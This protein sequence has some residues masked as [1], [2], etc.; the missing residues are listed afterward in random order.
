MI[1]S[2]KYKFIFIKT[3]KTAGTSIEVFLSKYCGEQ[4]ILTPIDPPIE[5][6]IA[7][8]YSG[9]FNPLPEIVE[10]RFC[11]VRRTIGD[12]VRR[13]KFYNHIA[14]RIVKARVPKDVWN[15][16][17]K[18][19]VERNPW[20]KTLSHYYWLKNRR[21]QKQTWQEY[22]IQGQFRLNY[23]LYTDR[24]GMKIIVDHVIKYEHLDDELAEIFKNIGIPFS[25][26]L[27]VRAKSEYRKD[28]RPYWE[29]FTREQKEIIAQAFEKEIRLHGYEF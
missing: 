14:A 1:I 22:L 11:N 27:S 7:R 21:V 6:H 20:D 29:V 3:A 5:P 12:L 8:N 23:Q 24:K 28:R 10:E 19:C 17:F 13:R 26:N 18:F 25:G 9:L 15:T 2:H 16:Y 4:D